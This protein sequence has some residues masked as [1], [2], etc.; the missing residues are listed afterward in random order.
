MTDRDRF[1]AEAM[2]AIVNQCDWV[3]MDDDVVA[4][5]AYEIAD[6]MIDARTGRKAAGVDSQPV[7]GK[8]QDAMNLAIRALHR[9][10]SSSGLKSANVLVGMLE[11]LGG[12]YL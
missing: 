11:R 3:K 9:F 10:E 2:A 6:A 5:K 7:S 12:T 4:A 1:A 8:E